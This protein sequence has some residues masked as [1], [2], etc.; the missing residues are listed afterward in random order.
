DESPGDT[1]AGRPMSVNVGR[2]RAADTVSLSTGFAA[3]SMK[4]VRTGDVREEAQFR[5]TELVSAKALTGRSE[6][7]RFGCRYLHVSQRLE[8]R[9][10]LRLARN[11]P[12]HRVKPAIEGA[13]ALGEVHEPATFAVDRT[14]CGGKC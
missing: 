13:D 3:G 10:H 6:H 4:R 11:D 9:A 8:A 12:D 1:R 7:R 5:V 14:A 2:E